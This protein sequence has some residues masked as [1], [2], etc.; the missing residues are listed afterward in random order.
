MST[1]ID[2]LSKEIIEKYG[3]RRKAGRLSLVV[4]ITKNKAYPVPRNVEHTD[5]VKRFETDPSHLIPVHIDF[6]GDRVV[7]IDTGESGLEIKLGIKHSYD[8]LNSANSA[9]YRLIHE[10]GIELDPEHVNKIHS[11]HAV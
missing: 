3:S 5:F 1:S 10:S 2:S 6:D 11:E 9:A 4:D 8:D 7:G